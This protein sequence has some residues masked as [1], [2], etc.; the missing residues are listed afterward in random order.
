[1][2]ISSIQQPI[3]NEGMMRRRYI[4]QAEGDNAKLEERGKQEGK[5]R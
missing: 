2:E 5:E 1:M 4:Q 3:S